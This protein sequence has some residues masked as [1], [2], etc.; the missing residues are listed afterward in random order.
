MTALGGTLYFTAQTGK[1]TQ[2]WETNGTVAGTVQL[3]TANPGSGGVDPSYLVTLNGTLFFLANDPA[4]GQQ[5]LWSSNGTA[6]GT[7]VVT[8]LGGSSSYYPSGGYPS[9]DQI[10]ASDNSLFFLAGNQSSS[11]G[12]D[13]WESDGTA[14]GTTDVGSLP[15]TPSYLVADGPTL[16][17]P[18][19]GDQGTELWYAQADRDS[20]PHAN[21]NTHAHGNSDSD[22]H[23][24]SDT[25]TYTHSDSDSDSDYFARSDSEVHSSASSDPDADSRADHHRRARDLP[26]QDQ[27]ERQARGQTRAHRVYSGV[28]PADGTGRGECRRISARQS[29]SEVGGEEQS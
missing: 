27:Q 19:T 7:S 13:L 20:D 22:T 21:S 25:Y 28:Q 5:A 15:E 9:T 26:S 29:A 2:L 12:P 18:A 4:T 11:N 8:D 10:V 1:D 6:G 23:A 24:H 16:F 3:T 14:A 17:F